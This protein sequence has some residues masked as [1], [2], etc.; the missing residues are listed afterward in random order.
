MVPKLWVTNWPD[1]CEEYSKRLIP[2]MLEEYTYQS[3]MKRGR[4]ITKPLTEPPSLTTLGK[5]YPDADPNRFKPEMLVDEDDMPI[6]WARKR[7][8]VI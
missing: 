7:P 1:K 3:G 8:R 2:Q 4:T 6:C 5:K